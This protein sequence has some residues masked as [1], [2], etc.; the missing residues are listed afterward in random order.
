VN[1]IAVVTFKVYLL[2]LNK[3]NTCGKSI[4]ELIVVSL[5]VLKVRGELTNP[6][7]VSGI[8]DIKILVLGECT[9]DSVV[10]GL[11]YRRD[12]ALGRNSLIFDNTKDKLCVGVVLT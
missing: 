5:V 6:L 4:V 1:N 10:D 7:V 9:V 2:K 12:T 8:V 11:F 3:L